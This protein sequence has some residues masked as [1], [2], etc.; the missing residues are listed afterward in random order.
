MGRAVVT[1]LEDQSRW[2]RADSTHADRY[3]GLLALAGPDLRPDA[4]VLDVGCGAGNLL[5]KLPPCRAFGVDVEPAIL[6]GGVAGDAE[7]LPFHDASF[8]VVFCSEVIEHVPDPDRLVAELR[9]VLHPGGSAVV[10]TINRLSLRAIRKG[11]PLT[12]KMHS[13]QHLR[14]Y[15]RGTLHRQLRRHFIVEEFLCVGV[16]RSKRDLMKWIPGGAYR[17]PLFHYLMFR[18]RRPARPASSRIP[19]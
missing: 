7:A 19:A 3:R 2:L 5:A 17:W 6:R 18:V 12:G 16:R 8:D 11:K 9:R 10:S 15:S 1:Q 13:I 4:R 14:E